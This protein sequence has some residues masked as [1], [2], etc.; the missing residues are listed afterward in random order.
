MPYAGEITSAAAEK[1]VLFPMNSIYYTISGCFNE[2]FH[3]VQIW[4][5][6]NDDIGLR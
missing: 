2:A 3:Q 1:C 5:T 6:I 4:P